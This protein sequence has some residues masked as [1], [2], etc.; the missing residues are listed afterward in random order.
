MKHFDM[1]HMKNLMSVCFIDSI[2]TKTKN[3][4]K[5]LS[6]YRIQRQFQYFLCSAE[7]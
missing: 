3:H 1:N 6:L 5:N 2:F 4:P 7:R